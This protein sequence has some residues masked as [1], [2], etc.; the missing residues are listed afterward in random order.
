M[1]NPEQTQPRNQGYHSLRVCD[2]YSTGFSKCLTFRL[3]G[4]TGRL[5]GVHGSVFPQPDDFSLILMYGSGVTLEG[6]Q[7][8]SSLVRETSVRETVPF[9]SPTHLIHSVVAWY[10]ARIRT[11]G[12]DAPAAAKRSSTP[13]NAPIP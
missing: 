13:V 11:A 12:T 3:V 9:L 1:V 10:N 4:A 5:M 8:H 6:F 2:E 7:E